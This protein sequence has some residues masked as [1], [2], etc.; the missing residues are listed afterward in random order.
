MPKAPVEPP[1]AVAMP[2]T[3]PRREP[4]LRCTRRRVIG[5]IVSARPGPRQEAARPPSQQAAKPPERMPTP[6][7]SAFS[8]VRNLQLYRLDLDDNNAPSSA[9]TSTPRGNSTSKS[10]LRESSL[11]GTYDMLGVELH[12]MD[13]NE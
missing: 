7:G 10:Q 5:A 6:R 13:D 3:T 4:P 9:A 12:R 2:P 8:A 11:A 1:S